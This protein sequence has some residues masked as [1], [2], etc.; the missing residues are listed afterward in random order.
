MSQWSLTSH[1]IVA[2][3]HQKHRVLI[4]PGFLNQ[5]LAELEGARLIESYVEVRSRRKTI[6]RLTD[7]G[8]DAVEERQRKLNEYYNSTRR[9]IIR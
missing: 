9:I 5:I 2:E 8:R 1:G 4:S 7:K 3:I 6:Y